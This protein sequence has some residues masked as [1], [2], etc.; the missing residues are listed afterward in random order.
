[1]S[2]W[3]Y[4]FFLFAPAVELSAK[5]YNVKIDTENRKQKPLLSFMSSLRKKY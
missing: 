4:F 1:M 3:K 2:E 5:V